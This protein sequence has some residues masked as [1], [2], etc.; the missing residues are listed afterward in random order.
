LTYE[1]EKSKALPLLRGTCW[2]LSLNCW[3]HKAIVGVVHLI[4]TLPGGPQNFPQAFKDVYDNF[5][6]F[7]DMKFFEEE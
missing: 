3:P 2:R 5:K 7:Y 4:R 6:L 1:T